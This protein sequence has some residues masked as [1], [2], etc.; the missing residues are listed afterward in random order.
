MVFS[1]KN[2]IG[3][4]GILLLGDVCMIYNT[5]SMLIHQRLLES[6]H[7]ILNVY[8]SCKKLV[9]TRVVFRKIDNKVG[10]IACFHPNKQSIYA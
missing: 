5:R 7:S 10:D 8:H 2:G 6:N 9:T 4:I 3:Q 1:R